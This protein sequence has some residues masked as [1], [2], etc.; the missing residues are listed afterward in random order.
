[1]L[2][3]IFL[4][5]AA[6]E[7]VDHPVPSGPWGVMKHKVAYTVIIV[8]ALMTHGLL[9]LNDGHYVDG[10]PF[11][12]QLVERKLDLIFSF[13]MRQGLPGHT[14][15]HWLMDYF[16]GLIFKYRVIAFLSILLAAILVYKICVESKLISHWESLFI[17]L[18]SLTYP[19]FQASVI[20][21]VT[22]YL[23][24][25]FLFILATYLAICSER[26]S[27]VVRHSL[28]GCSVVLFFL[29]FNLNSLLVFYFGFLFFLLTH[30]QRLKR[31]TFKQAFIQFV[32]RRLDFLLLP[33][34]FWIVKEHFFPRYG[35]H[36]AYNRFQFSPTTL[37]ANSGRFFID[38]I[39][40]QLNDALETM[41]QQLALA[42]LLL[43]AVYGAYR[44]FKMDSVPSS[45]SRLS[46]YTLLTFG[47][48][49]LVL[50]ILPYVV[51]GLGPARHGFETRHALLV[52]LPMALI[53]TGTVRLVF[54]QGETGLPKTALVVLATLV[55]AFS[56]TVVDN[57]FAWQ[58]RWVKDR[59]IMVNLSPLSEFKRMSIFWVDDQFQFQGAPG[60]A[61]YD[62]SSIF[63][64]M[65]GG[66]SR[67]GLNQQFSMLE[68]LADVVRADFS[69]S[70]ILELFNISD[71]DPAGC[72]AILSISRGRLASPDAWKLALHYLFLK[73]L[74]PEEMTQ[75]LEGITRVHVEPISVP[76]AVNCRT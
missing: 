62:W 28:H 46:P 57:Y 4:L 12:T 30:E 26:T 44:A 60:Y 54:S 9:L 55:V 21:P 35:P 19:A 53:L 40:G 38:A 2:S 31:C 66:E 36:A 18:I 65:W 1:M 64:Q 3:D 68:A 33:F 47:L 41:L 51:V 45:D 70:R 10:W 43:M 76:E 25:Y 74:K 11:Y 37:I 6:K 58:A 5:E 56:M 42:L 39:Y 27:G 8:I 17:A 16:P 49:L 13:H 75:F 15:I 52:G 73:L 48:V 29:S 23:I 63:K 67:V 71:L 34:V 69:R 22:V 59:S 61:F 20:T 32:P 7:Q 72:Q 14:F 50:G 24:F